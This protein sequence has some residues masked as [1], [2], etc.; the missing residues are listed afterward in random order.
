[1]FH[2]VDFISMWLYILVLLYLD[3]VEI[4]FGRVEE[5]KAEENF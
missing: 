3:G 4:T 1:M 2:T 5:F